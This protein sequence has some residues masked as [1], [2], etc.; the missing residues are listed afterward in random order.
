MP[1]V[2]YSRALSFSRRTTFSFGTGS[3][4]VAS[5]RLQL[6]GAEPRT[7]VP[8]A[9]ERDL[10]HELGRTWTAQ[11][12]YARGPSCRAMAVDELYSTDGL[13]AAINGLVTRRFSLSAP[14][15]WALSSLDRP[16]Q[17]RHNGA[18]GDGAA[19]LCADAVSGRSTLATSITSTSYDEGIP[20]DPRIARA[21]D[22]QGVRV[23][24]TTSIP[25]IR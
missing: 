12:G 23:G 15:T 25:L 2:N 1:G 18:V 22:R 4:I 8:S 13:T 16:G 19:A 10:A 21:M 6:D 17:N 7:Q 11:L 3:A 14:A 9:G 24:L 5:E 20:L